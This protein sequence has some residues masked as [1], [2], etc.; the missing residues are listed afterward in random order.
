LKP[1]T[2]QDALGYSPVIVKLKEVKP[3]YGKNGY[4]PKERVSQGRGC[5]KM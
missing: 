2:N 5:L 4:T 1:K 3:D